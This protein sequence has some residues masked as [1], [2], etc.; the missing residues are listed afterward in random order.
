MLVY[1]QSMDMKTMDE[2]SYYIY[3]A[4]NDSAFHTRIG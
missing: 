1:F 2:I 3:E 4:E